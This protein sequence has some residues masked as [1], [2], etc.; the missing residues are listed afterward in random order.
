MLWAQMNGK[1]R[2]QQL[3]P[4]TILFQA[5]YHDYSKLGTLNTVS[6]TVTLKYLVISLQAME[7][8][9]KIPGSIYLVET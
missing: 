5:A 6:E 8:Y 4:L 9:N 3:M 2:Y 1:Q 7:T